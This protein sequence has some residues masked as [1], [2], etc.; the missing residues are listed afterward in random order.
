MTKLLGAAW[1]II[2]TLSLPYYGI[3]D[4]VYTNG[5]TSE[6]DVNAASTTNIRFDGGRNIFKGKN[7]HKSRKEIMVNLTPSEMLIGHPPSTIEA[8]G[9]EHDKEIVDVT[10]REEWVLRVEMAR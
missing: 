10:N 1:N 9:D 5:I 3:R 4:K 8:S 7:Q 6:G 2:E